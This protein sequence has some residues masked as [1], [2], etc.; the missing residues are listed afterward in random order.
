MPELAYVSR[1]THLMGATITISFLPPQNDAQMEYPSEQVL[2]EVFDLL[3]IY[4]QR[5]SANDANSELMQVNHAA[6]KR[7]I[8]VRP[9]LKKANNE[10]RT[11][12]AIKTKEW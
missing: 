10:A 5:F 8:Q 7:P 11:I 3:H 6:G 1:S 12:R 2:N 9:Q 4:N